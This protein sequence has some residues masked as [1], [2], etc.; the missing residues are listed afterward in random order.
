MHI[1]QIAAERHN[2]P[3][4][5]FSL[6]N[7]ISSSQPTFNH[8]M[9]Q[10]YQNAQKTARDFNDDEAVWRAFEH[11][12]RMRRFLG[13]TWPQSEQDTDALDWEWAERHARPVRAIGFTIP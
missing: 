13:S 8:P 11:R 2:D 5:E 6:S 1:P 9:T 7:M 10:I 12:K 3:A 4:S